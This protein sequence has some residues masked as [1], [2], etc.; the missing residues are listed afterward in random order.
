[1]IGSF[2]VISKEMILCE[3]AKNNDQLFS[4]KKIHDPIIHLFVLGVVPAT[5]QIYDLQAEEC[6]EKLNDIPTCSFDKQFNE[7]V[8]SIR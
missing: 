3:G 4:P 1:M 7:M 8:L 6:N 5:L 2:Y